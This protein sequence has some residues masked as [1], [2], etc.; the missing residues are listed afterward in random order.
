MT[1]I[2]LKS[3]MRAAQIVS[4]KQTRLHRL[5]VPRPGPD[6]VIIQ[7]KRAGICGTDIHILHG[8]YSLAKF[9][10]VP[11]H[12]FCGV[13]S[14]V[15]ERVSRFKVGD[16]VTADP[17]IPCNRCPS[18]QRNEQNQCQR[19]EVVGVSRDGAFAE[20]VSVPEGVVFGIGDMNFAQGALIEPL[21]CVVWGL[22]Q[23]QIQTGDNLLIFGAGPMGCLI[24]QAA[25]RAGATSVTM[26]DRAA[27]R[28][29]VAKELG[30]DHVVS[31][32]ALGELRKIA[33]EGFEVV[34]D[35]TGV[36][37]VLEQCFDYV[38]ARGKVWVF[39]V[40]P[41]HAKASFS[42]YQVFRK[43]LKIIGSFALNKT[44]QESINLI[45]SGAVK[46]EPLISHVLPIEDFEKGLELAEKDPK[47]MKVQFS[48]D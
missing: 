45:Q 23:V 13:V 8:E 5:D 22:K 42:P 27:W 26:V 4:P 35:A 12:E 6:D 16:S 38:R 20:Y 39:G 15:G 29:D 25:K 18:C 40:A 19:L 10:M 37:A 36:P 9:P 48:F 17:N 28:L 24:M 1:E 7:V 33:A 44:F 34:A 32:D 11:G 41:D 14:A 21:A 46:L 3:E 30:A 31:S 2:T 43:D 47:R